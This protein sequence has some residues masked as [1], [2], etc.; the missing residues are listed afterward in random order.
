MSIRK[1]VVLSE[2]DN[3]DDSGDDETVK[4]TTLDDYLRAGEVDCPKIDFI[5][6]DVEGVEFS[7]LRGARSILTENQDILVFFECTWQGCELS[8]H[9]ISEVFI[10]LRELGFGL[11]GWRPESKTWDENEDYLSIVGNIWAC[12][13]KKT[14][15]RLS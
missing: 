4:V 6:M 13:D 14:L 12:R 11:Y 8:G 9:K 1:D 15:P 2:L 5:K 10:Y 3:H 7:V